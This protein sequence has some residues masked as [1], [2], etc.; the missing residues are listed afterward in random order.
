MENVLRYI[1]HH[2]DEFVERLKV[3]LSQPSVAA[4]NLGME[5]CAKLVQ[6]MLEGIGFQT[7][8]LPTDGFPVVYG[9]LQ[10]ERDRVLMFYDHYDVQP[11]EPLEL[12]ESDPWSPQ[13][14][15]GKLYARGSSDNKGDL[16][17]R[18]C[19]L[20]AYQKT[21]GRL[22]VTIKFVIEGEE[23]I[24]SPHLGQFVKQ[25]KNLLKADG[26]IW[27]FGHKDLQDVP[28]IY[29]GL[30]G[31]C[32]VEVHATGASGDQH[33]SWGTVVPNPAWRL[34]WA[35]S[36]LKD[37][38]EKI[39]INGFYKTVR[40]PSKAE[41]KTVKHLDF[42][43]RGW[44]TK[45]GIKDYLL[46]LSGAQLKKKHY[47]EPTC[48]ICGIWSGYT[49]QGP[50]TVLPAEARAKIDFRLVPDQDPEEILALLKKHLKR[51]GFGDIEVIGMHGVN[52]AR[53]PMDDP[54]VE[55]VQRTAEEI[56]GVEP[57]VHPTSAASGPMYTLCEKLGI[58]AVSTGIGY[59]HS[60]T[61]APNENIRLDDFM[62]GVK[63][64][65]RIVHGYSFKA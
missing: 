6:Q 42:D 62:Q 18:L 35:L 65:A 3:L 8:M 20:E 58:P 53:T 34:V 1:D 11:P 26:C 10:G 60:N 43:E 57:V 5:P 59:A 31:I 2:R 64:I 7:Q 27:E 36:T 40:E 56:Y 48:T 45:F 51:H 25:H 50:K 14:R 54:L 49:G 46:K 4:Q 29:L 61:H 9:E 16:M 33:S 47:F 63:H 44:R 32:Y 17:A 37:K 23:E 41:L 52:P 19:A 38:N 28:Q 21:M 15:D 24:G 55:I 13:I 22:P 30:K 39:C 12:W